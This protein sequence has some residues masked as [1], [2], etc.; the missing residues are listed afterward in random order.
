MEDP[1]ASRILIYQPHFN[2]YFSDISTQN[3]PGT[4]TAGTDFPDAVPPSRASP[5][6]PPQ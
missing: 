6:G 5:P 2:R 3:A 4:T 1:L